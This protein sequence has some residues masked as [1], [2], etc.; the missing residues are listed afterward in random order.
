[1]ADIGSGTAT[2]ERLATAVASAGSALDQDL[3]EISTTADCASVFARGTVAAPA[4][5]QPAEPVV[6]LTGDLA[7]PSERYGADGELACPVVDLPGLADPGA[8][9]A[10]LAAHDH[11]VT[12]WRGDPWHP[13]LLQ[14]QAEFYPVAAGTN[15]GADDHTYDPAY[16]TGNHVL[17]PVDLAPAPGRDGLKKAAN[18]YTGTTLLS[19]RTQPV[20]ADRILRYLA[21]AIL[22][23]TTTE[24]FLADPGPE[25]T[26]YAE[27]GKDE[28]LTTL[29]EVYR[30]L[31]AH[32]RDNLAQSLGGFNDALVMRRLVRQL[33][34][35]DPLGFPEYQAFAARVAAAVGGDTRQA[36]HPDS[37]FNPIRSG[38]LRISRLRVVD[39]FGRAREIPVEDLATTTRLRIPG[40][41]GWV[42][43]P[44]R[45]TQPARLSARWL[46]S[47]HDLRHMND[48]PVTSP[49]CGWLVPDDLDAGFAV[50]DAAGA[51][52]GVLQAAGAEVRWTPGPGGTTLERVVDPHLR[53]TV[54]GLMAL[55]AADLGLSLAGVDRALAGVE[56][57]DHGAPLLTGRPLA[58]V[59]AEFELRLHGLPAVHQDWNVFRQDLHRTGREDDAFPLVRFPVRIGAADRL[60]DG[61]VALWDGAALTSGDIGL[62]LVLDQPHR[63]TLLVDPR[64]PVHVTSGILPG[65][66]LRLPPAQYQPALDGMTLA[67]FAAPVLTD[68]DRL[69]LP[70]PSVPGH[71]WAW[72]EVGLPDADLDDARPGTAFPDPPVLR[73]GWLA[74]VPGP[75]EGTR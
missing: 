35:A 5:H 46:D 69:D 49:V 7:R 32:E 74:L 59:R 66:A 24:A 43:M 72:Q 51:R 47:D 29:I 15:L 17:G 61:L 6:L 40:R 54:Q 28:R 39:S 64:A 71:H 34:I 14:W 9:R 56:P 3:A 30:H 2:L 48:V 27:H 33:P 19:D 55:G 26:R 38:A 67:F 4:Y 65:K 58:L 63:L 13:V 68:G 50:Y 21:S 75:D 8:A 52:L 37:D 70:V 36:P 62:E 57:D 31:A 1:M 44:P 12:V 16:I 22:E 42:A 11:P 73:E 23:K 41:P 18:V 20:L 60:D 45:L 53:E 25:L 10:A